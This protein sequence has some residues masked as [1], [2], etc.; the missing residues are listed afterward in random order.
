MLELFS[1]R[2]CIH[3]AGQSLHV[4]RGQGLCMKHTSLIYDPSDTTCKYQ[5]RKDLPHFVLD[6]GRSEHA[7]EFA[8]FTG[9]VSLCDKKPIRK[10]LY[11]EKFVWEQRQFD[12]INNALASYHKAGRSWVL[13]QSFA[14]GVDGPRS[15]VHGCLI[16]RYLDQCGS[17]T[18]SY[19]M[20]LALVQEMPN[21]PVFA[22]DVLCTDGNCEPEEV[23]RQARWDLFFTQLSGL[24]EYGWHAGLEDLMWASDAVNGGLSELDWDALRPE[25]SNVCP[26]WIDRIIE[27]AQEN[28]AFFT[29][30]PQEEDAF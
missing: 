23:A 13:I 26:K 10:V 17:W 5:H 22:A 9:L 15:L 6:E 4:G 21:D 27:H 3:N 7:A 12:P 8:A 16:R 2:N 19:R 29:Q 18:S 20:T 24:Q 14:G 11:S 1:C 30:L 25:L 28:D